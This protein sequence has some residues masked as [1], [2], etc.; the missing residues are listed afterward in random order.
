VPREKK[1]I[2][3]YH[4]VS[5]PLPEVFGSVSFRTPIY[6]RVQANRVGDGKAQEEVNLSAACHLERFLRE[7]EAKIGTGS[8]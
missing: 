7:K 1:A 6:R 4:N 2:A 5:N 3:A 8:K